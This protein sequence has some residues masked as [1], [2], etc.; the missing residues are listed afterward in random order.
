VLRTAL[1]ACPSDPQNLDLLA[2]VHDLLGDYLQAG[3]LRGQALRIRRVSAKPSVTFTADPPEIERGQTTSLSWNTTNATA[4]EIEPEPG[5]VAAKGTRTVAPGADTTYRL[6]ARGPGGEIT[7]TVDIP[8]RLPRLTPEAV[9][10]LL[11][12]GVAAPRITKLAGERGLTFEMTPLLEE[13]FR[14]AGADDELLEALRK[15]PH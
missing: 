9:V 8:V 5:P 14:A 11:T 13:K 2:E 1:F 7:A 10:D 4:I 12:S 3:K 6:T 15:A